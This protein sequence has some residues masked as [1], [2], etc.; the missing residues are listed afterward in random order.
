MKTSSKQAHAPLSS[1]LSECSQ[2]LEDKN[3]I[4]LSILSEQIIKGYPRFWRGYWY[5]SK[6]LVA[7]ERFHEL[8]ALS[9]DLINQEVEHLQVLIFVA[10]SLYESFLYRASNELL[11]YTLAISQYYE[12]ACRI[13]LK[14]KSCLNLHNQACELAAEIIR[15]SGCSPFLLKDCCH[16]LWM[17]REYKLAQDA[18]NILMS[19]NETRLYALSMKIKILGITND[20][21]ASFK[22]ISGSL[23]EYP[24]STAL[25]TS[26]SFL[27]DRIRSHIIAE[28]SSEVISSMYMRPFAKRILGQYDFISSI[29]PNCRNTYHV[30]RIFDI[31]EAGP[32]DWNIS[33][34]E[35]LIRIFSDPDKLY[36]NPSDLVR[37]PE[38]RT[39]VN[40]KWLFLHHHDFPRDTNGIVSKALDPS[41]S[42]IVS[43]LN[44]KYRF[45]LNRFICRLSRAKRPLLICN[46]DVSVKNFAQEHSYALNDPCYPLLLEDGKT[47]YRD[48]HK[49]LRNSFNNEL[50]TLLISNKAC[51][52]GIHEVNDGFVCIHAP[53][54]LGSADHSARAFSKPY[55][56]YDLAIMILSTLF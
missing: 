9:Q 15:K 29:G 30:R 26:K 22:A 18:V 47:S 50:T 27:V 44:D 28:A 34:P 16:L 24:N 8:P 21:R 48:V 2:L 31:E 13:A 38:G 43:L 1:L 49:L 20:F 12:P 40:R 41:C 54:W 19:H 7:L 11:D 55:T 32:L 14:V 25:L 4:D 23:Q 56:Q 17:N 33:V 37:H 39:V 42:D 5:K 36:I 51:R 35:S 46:D 3:Y 52:S 6:S 53:K 10:K 45:L